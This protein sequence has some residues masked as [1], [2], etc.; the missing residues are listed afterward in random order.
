M[1]NGA[2]VRTIGPMADFSTSAV[3][4]WLT[5]RRGAGKR[6]VGRLTAEVLRAEGRTC[7][8]L[9]AAALDAHLAR[10]PSDGG[11]ESLAW[12]AG[13]LTESGVTTIVTVDTARRADRDALRDQIPGFVEVLIDAPAEVCAD[14][15]GFADPTYEPPIAPDLRIPTHD[16]DERASTAQLVSYV[17]SLRDG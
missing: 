15:A 14:R 13:L 6:T 8:V 10:G 2:Q 17:E 9:D 16:R 4:I 1:A 7:A 5:G 3:C 12:L 11:L